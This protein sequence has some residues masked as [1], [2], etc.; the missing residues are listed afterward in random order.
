MKLSNIFLRGIAIILSIVAFG[1][2]IFVITEF[3]E[4]TILSFP[5]I[6][7]T[8][9]FVVSLVSYPFIALE[10]N[11]VIEKIRFLPS[12]SIL[13]VNFT[14]APFILFKRLSDKKE[15]RVP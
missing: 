3:T 14:L 7:L 12:S 15:N 8:I 13:L 4:G 2:Y 6:L 9:Y 1:F 5:Y 11:K 10:D